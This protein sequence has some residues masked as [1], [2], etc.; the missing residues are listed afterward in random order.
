MLKAQLTKVPHG[1]KRDLVLVGDELNAFGVMVV[2]EILHECCVPFPYRLF[3]TSV[4]V[5]PFRNLLTAFKT[6]SAPH[7]SHWSLHFRLS[8]TAYQCQSLASH[9]HPKNSWVSECVARLKVFYFSRTS[10]F[11]LSCVAHL[12]GF[13]L[14]V[15]PN[16]HYT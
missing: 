10:P 16:I 6:H 15:I 9:D 11:L 4:C 5:E 7:S 13:N 8:G 3:N 1:I 12:V 2:S 14:T